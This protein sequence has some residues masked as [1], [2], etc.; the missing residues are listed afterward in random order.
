VAGLQSLYGLVRGQVASKN[1]D[2]SK[3]MEFG[4]AYAVRA[5]PQQRLTQ[6]PGLGLTWADYSNF[7]V[8]VFCAHKIGDA[9]ADPARQIGAPVGAG[10]K[11]VL[12]ITPAPGRK[13][14]GPEGF[15]Q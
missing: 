11:A 2:I 8:K 15:L 12:T 6:R 13:A 5:E 7:V 3:K 1:L 10:R 14:H 9:V 4:G